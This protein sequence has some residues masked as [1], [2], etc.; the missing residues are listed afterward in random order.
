MSSSLAASQ[1][2]EA[3]L[4]NGQA[5]GETVFL[6]VHRHPLVLSPRLLT[7]VLVAW[8]PWVVFILGSGFSLAFGAAFILTTVAGLGYLFVVWSD[9]RHTLYLVT[10]HR[11]VTTWQHNIW[12]RQVREVPLAKIQ[13]VKHEQRGFLK[14]ALRVGDV[15][16]RTAAAELHL[17]DVGDPYDIEQAIGR[18][19]HRPHTPKPVS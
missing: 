18:L 8:I 1:K 7:V 9:W 12:Q 6:A 4:F 16:V 2:T 14:I 3:R 19:I 10:N 5:A 15:I 11:V 13:E 17:R